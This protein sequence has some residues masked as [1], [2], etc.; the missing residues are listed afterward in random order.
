MLGPPCAN[1]NAASGT[2]KVVG[3][4]A[5]VTIPVTFTAAYSIPGAGV[6]GT[7]TFT[8]TLVGV[9]AVPEPSSMALVGLVGIGVVVR[10]FRKKTAK[11]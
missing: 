2:Y 5:T 11:V 8:G 9:T 3:G 6:T 1:V 4:I 10:R 7:N